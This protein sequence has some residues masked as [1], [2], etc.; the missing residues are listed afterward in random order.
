MVE[1]T[2]Q[3]QKHAELIDITKPVAE[4]LRGL[5]FQ[6]G[7][8]HLFVPHTT[9]AITLNESVDPQVGGDLLHDLERLVPEGNS[10]GHR[11]G[12]APAH[13]KAALIGQSVSL[14]VVDGR[15]AL[16][17]WQAVFLCEFDGPRARQ[18]RVT[19]VS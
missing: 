17:T 18:V 3:T 8:C 15:L 2:F 9:A 4:A 6:E 1:L 10:Y 11:E 14:P 12:N 5:N 13:I 7:V 16:G 19:V